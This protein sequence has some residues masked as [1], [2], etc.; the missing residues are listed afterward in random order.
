MDIAEILKMNGL[1]IIVAF[2]AACSAL[3][4]AAQDLPATQL[5]VLGGLSTRAMY[6]D[7]EMPFWLKVVP[8]K[9]AGKVTA[10]IKAF[11][12]MGLKGPELFRL[13]KQGVIEFGVI[14]FSYNL[15]ETPLYEGIDLAGMTPD[16]A[17]AKLV[18]KSY[19]PVLA[20]SLAS[21][22]QI[23]LLGI[24][25]YAS[26]V[27]FCN[28]P[29]RGLNDLKGKTIRTV[30]RS[31]SDLVEALGAKNATI[32]F[33]DVLNALKKKKI[34]C[35]VA[36]PM[37]AYQAKWYT[38]ATHIYALPVGWN[39]EVHAVNQATWDQLDPRVQTFLNQNIKDLTEQLWNFSASQTQIAYDCLTGAKACKL[40][41][42]G[43]MILV[44]PT[45]NDINAVKK[46][47]AQKVAVKWANR[48]SSQCIA[49]FNQS[50]GKALKVTV[51]K[52]T[53]NP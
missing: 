3:H 14:P 17:S 15:S 18:V 29:V 53:P 39:Q 28:V 52:Q 40:T 20:Q 10:E 48:C 5:K 8:E 32:A 38:A 34:A 7:V 23:K 2:F 45:Q 35:A 27:L 49:E 33:N 26:Q 16:V 43:K 41:P 46:I 50:V 30:N 37:S 31:Q 19:M 1:R 22:Q 51:K 6:K 12:E 25:P 42:K 44:R 21:S 36:G 4:V 47:A 24:S 11:D 9:S 13:M